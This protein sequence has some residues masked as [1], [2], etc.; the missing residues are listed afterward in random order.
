MDAL[1]IQ[2][3][4][5]L[6][7]TVDI[8]GAKNAALPMMAAT[9]LCP[10]PHRLSCVPNLADIRTL[11]TLLE[12]LG[13][14]VGR[15]GETLTIQSQNIHTLEAPYDLVRTMR[16]SFLL[17]G[18]LLAR[19]GRA[20]VSLPGGCAI[21]A[22]PVDQHLKGLIALGAEI[23]IEHGYVHA[24]APGGLKGAEVVFDLPTVGGTENLLLAAS[25][26]Q[27]ETI[28]RNAAREPEV[29][30]LARGLQAMGVT[31]EGAGT[32]IIRIV[33][34]PNL[35]PLNHRVVADRI[36]AGTFLIAAALVG[37]KVEVRG[38]QAEHLASLL[39]KLRAADIRV[40]TSANAIT[41]YGARSSQSRCE[42]GRS[43]KATSVT[44]AAYPGFPTD[45]QAQWM[46]LMALAHGTSQITETIFENRF[47]HVA[48][49]N[50]L[51]ASIRV[52][53]GQAVVEGRGGLSGTTV[54]A[55]DLRAS[56]CLVLAGL[57]AKGVTTVRRIYHLD[58][59]YDG[60]EGKLE[61]LGAQV[62]RVDA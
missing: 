28:L 39:A 25:L 38:A 8:S 3:G 32:A 60:L 14:S 11:T 6:A 49:L 10:G 1:Q 21:G 17:L 18:P 26:A 43:A 23:S 61:G 59:G 53:G 2:G 19:F 13:A 33:G 12:H 52:E 45:M 5:T 15:D 16:A 27:G 30:D 54:M 47:M 35:R 31:I 42:G 50:R 57:V 58:R 48:E 41:V 34:Q 62:L 36:E 51:G 44:T 9:L 4:R 29:V 20:K 46:T 7:G 40:E 56:A 37:D 24:Q 22:R 55:T